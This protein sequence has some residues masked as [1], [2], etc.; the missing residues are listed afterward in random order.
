MSIQI[1]NFKFLS[2]KILSMSNSISV[3]ENVKFW[4]ENVEPILND[5]FWGKISLEDGLKKL[6]ELVKVAPTSRGYEV[7][8]AKRRL[9]TQIRLL[10]N[11][12]MLFFA[13]QK[14]ELDFSN[15]YYS[16]MFSLI[17][18][19]LNKAKMAEKVK[20]HIKTL[21]RVLEILENY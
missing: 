15:Y 1:P 4:E 10:M 9:M 21:E 8:D 12:G 2:I 3:D 7:N 6:V 17:G 16:A 18:I 5:I 20:E 11:H 13:L 19:E 14:F